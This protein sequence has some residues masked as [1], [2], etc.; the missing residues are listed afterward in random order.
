EVP[1]R[2]LVFYGEKAP[3]LL[4]LRA[5]VDGKPL[6]EAHRAAW[7]EYVR[8]LFAHLDRNGDGSLDEREASAAPPPV[9]PSG[10]GGQA[11]FAFNF[12]VLDSNG[13]GR[14]S[15]EELAEYYRQFG[16]APFQVRS[17]GP[18]QPTD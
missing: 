11:R 2:K 7:D 6:D 17:L 13:D 8:R 10:V 9:L 16:D 14:V 15:L 18:G 12:A 5:L 4:G 1:E 3:V